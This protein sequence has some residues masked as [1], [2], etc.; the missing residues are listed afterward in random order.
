MQNL[1]TRNE[2]N[3]AKQDTEIIIGVVR[4]A[5]NEPTSSPAAPWLIAGAV[6]L[7]IGIVISNSNA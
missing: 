3:L 6:L 2:S 4:R 5:V 7:T 1:Y